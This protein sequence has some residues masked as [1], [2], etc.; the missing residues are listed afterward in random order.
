MRFAIELTCKVLP[1]LVLF[2]FKFDSFKERDIFFEL[3]AIIPNVPLTF[4]DQIL[5]YYVS[6]RKN[7]RTAI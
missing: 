4:A 3:F 2:K 1:L 7:S 6:N 5:V